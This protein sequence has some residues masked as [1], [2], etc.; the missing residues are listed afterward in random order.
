MK[1]LIEHFIT[2]LLLLIFIWIGIAYIIQN[3]TYSSARE[4]HGGVVAQLENSYFDAAVIED[5]RKK[6][7]EAGY[8]LE[9]V[10]YGEENRK[11]ARVTLGFRYVI[12]VAGIEKNYKIEGYSR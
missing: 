2:F 4:F 8:E 9:V 6:A 7:A 10:V 5:C 11:D 1:L 12:P 3:I